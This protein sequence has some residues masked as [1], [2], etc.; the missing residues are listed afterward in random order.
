MNL[1]VNIISNSFVIRRDNIP[2][3]R[4]AAWPL[5]CLLFDGEEIAGMNNSLLQIFASKFI[6]NNEDHKC[7]LCFFKSRLGT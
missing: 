3:V 5:N 6:L 1:S 4:L 2:T 7:R